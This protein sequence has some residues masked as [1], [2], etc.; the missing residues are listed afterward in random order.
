[1]TEAR[2]KHDLLSARFVITVL[3]GMITSCQDQ[4][5]VALPEV[6]TATVTEITGSSAMGGGTI[7]SPGGEQTIACGLVYSTTNP[8][9]SLNDNIIEA[10]SCT[11]PFTC[12][13]SNLTTGTTYHVRAF[14][15]NRFGTG[16][17]PTVTFTTANPLITGVMATGHAAVD[18]IL[19]ATYVSNGA[20]ATITCQWYRAA[21]ALGAG[22]T[23][24]DGASGNQYRVSV[25]DEWAYLCVGVTP[26]TGS[27]TPLGPEVRSAYIGPVSEKPEQIT[28][29]YNGLPVT[30]GVTISAA[31]GRKWLDRNLGAKR[32]ATGVDDYLA[33]GD[34]FQWGRAADGHQL[35]DWPGASSGTPVNG[36]SLERSPGDGPGH[37]LFIINNA[38]PLDWRAAHNN[39]LW[40]PPAYINNPCPAGWHI[41][42]QAE[43]QAENIRNLS[44]GFAALKL[45]SAG[46]RKLT[47]GSLTANSAQTRSGSYWT[48]TPSAA[49]NTLTTVFDLYP[50]TVEQGG[51]NE[52]GR[53]STGCSCRCIKNE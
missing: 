29:N 22:E 26:R 3:I 40:Q 8:Q 36:T 24:I 31:T 28:F 52:Y 50:G 32:S 42:T 10:G 53:R 16:Y 30:Y 25:S 4:D 21:D 39:N 34:L 41:P 44:D 7:T 33:Y 9:P 12:K 6:S 51:I 35:I 11:G 38:L 15:T 47:D 17:G 46:Q 1:M 37:A 18:S 13:I 5:P 27:G 48:S 45:V 23:L 20:A 19:T 49:D 2:Q 43:W 14:A